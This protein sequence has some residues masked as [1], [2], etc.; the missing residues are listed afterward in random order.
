MNTPPKLPLF[1]Q[2]FSGPTV[3]RVASKSTNAGRLGPG[4]LA[5]LFGSEPASASCRSGK[6]S[7]SVSGFSGSV[8]VSVRPTKTPVSVSTLSDKPSPSVSATK[9][10]V[11]A[12]LPPTIR[13][14]SV[15]AMVGFGLQTGPGVLLKTLWNSWRFVSPSPSGSS[16]PSAT[17]GF[18]VGRY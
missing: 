4:V 14:T 18:S 6:V 9:G 1:V 13:F 5:A 10:F 15:S 17:F 11:G 8:P 3:S 12:G 16:E 2:L 7:L